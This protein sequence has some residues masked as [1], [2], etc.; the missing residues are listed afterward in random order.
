MKI[1][2][3]L[4][5]IVVITFLISCSE[6]DLKCDSSTAKRTVKELFE[7][8]MLKNIENLKLYSG[9][10]EDYL[11]K[12]YQQNIKLNSIRTKSIN[13]EL[14]SCECSADIELNLKPEI[15]DYILQK[16][17]KKQ[18]TM[19]ETK[20][21]ELLSQ[22]VR[23]DYSIQE[24]TDGEIYVETTMPDEM[25]D[26]LG[27]SNN[28]EKFYKENKLTLEKGKVYS[29]GYGTEDC[30]YEIT[31]TINK[32]ESVEG[33]H[34]QNCVGDNG[35]G[36]RKFKGKFKNGK[37]IGEIKGAESFELNFN[38]KIMEY[39]LTKSIM[40]NGKEINYSEESRSRM[41]IKYELIE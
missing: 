36:L 29:F 11:K 35:A 19:S 26:L 13:K 31:F 17:Q 34:N 25:G 28:F 7:E 6:D 5:T 38:D 1:V 12:F 8:E 40:Q 20:I 39:T 41:T 23:V 15:I 16:A 10:N 27:T 3:L 37:I 21:K 9:I 14:K 4:L 18:V 30:S 24:T 2:K 22:R 33:T 32:N